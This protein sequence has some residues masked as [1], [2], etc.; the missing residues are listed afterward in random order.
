MRMSARK[1]L[2]III[3]LLLVV[4]LFALEIARVYFIMPFPG[5]QV[6]NTVSV[7]YFL[8]ATINWMRFVLLILLIYPVYT[9]FKRSGRKGRTL[10]I[11]L[12]VLYELVFY[13]FNF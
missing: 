2:W 1:P 5:S 11:G 4:L 13:F 8:S 12:T 7:A 10:V 3:S 6:S 9:Q